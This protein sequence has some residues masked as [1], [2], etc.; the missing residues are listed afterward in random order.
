METAFLRVKGTLTLWEAKMSR[1]FP[2]DKEQPVEG[3][4]SKM[5]LI[6]NKA[7]SMIFFTA[8]SPDI[9]FDAKMSIFKFWIKRSVFKNF[10]MKILISKIL[11]G[12][13]PLGLQVKETFNDI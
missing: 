12:N 6:T 4:S 9:T 1:K 3:T 13:T 10:K 11:V 2:I 8:G 5:C 7:F